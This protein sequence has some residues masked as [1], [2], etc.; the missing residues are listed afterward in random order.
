MVA[1]VNG[2]LGADDVSEL[3]EMIVDV[4]VSPLLPEAFD[5]QSCIRV[6]SPDDI[7]LVG[8]CST[9][10]SLYLGVSDLLNQLSCYNQCHILSKWLPMSMSE[11]R[12]KAK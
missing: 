1:L 12:Q 11:K 6:N 3:L 8:Q 5:E 2:Y 9:Y 4:L 7:L 10:P